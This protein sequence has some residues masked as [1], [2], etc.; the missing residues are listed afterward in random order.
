MFENRIHLNIFGR[1]S[2]RSRVS[3][4][5]HWLSGNGSAA[6]AAD[7]CRG[8]DF[9]HDC[10]WANGARNHLKNWTFSSEYLAV[11]PI[12]QMLEGLYRTPIVTP[13]EWFAVDRISERKKEHHVGSF[14]S[15]YL[16]DDLNYITL[17]L[18]GRK[19]NE[20]LS[21]TNFFQRVA[22]SRGISHFASGISV[23]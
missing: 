22:I 13:L 11:T 8:P 5:D 16:N 15:P 3:Q 20:S 7:T 4:L 6:Q 21:P 12:A 14:I 23:T 2:R 9:V 19:R 18:Q 1:G 10:E 17:K